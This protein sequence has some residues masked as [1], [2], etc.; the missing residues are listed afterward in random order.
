[1]NHRVHQSRA[2]DVLRQ[3]VGIEVRE[4]LHVLLFFVRLV[5]E[6]PVKLAV[7]ELLDLDGFLEMT[8]PGD[9][10]R[11][12]FDTP[13]ETG[14]GEGETAA[15]AHPPGADSVFVHFR[16]LTQEIDSSHQI[17]VR[18]A[19]VV[20]VAILD[21]ISGLGRMGQLPLDHALPLTT[22]VQRKYAVAV[23]KRSG[24]TTTEYRSS[25]GR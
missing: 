11:G 12:G 9:L 23:S 4:G 13:V 16:T 21:V 14:N 19:I 5:L 1:M 10:G 20:F 3:V 18:A 17:G 7:D 15:L 2:G 24:S 8:R 6:Q 25:R 22:R